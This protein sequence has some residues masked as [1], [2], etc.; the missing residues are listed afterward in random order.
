ML[1]STIVVVT[2]AGRIF[3]V[4]LLYQGKAPKITELI[5]WVMKNPMIGSTAGVATE[6]RSDASQ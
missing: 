5:G 3:Q 4:G 1:V 6:G 2:V